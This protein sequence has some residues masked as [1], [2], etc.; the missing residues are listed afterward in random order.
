LPSTHLFGRQRQ[1][2]SDA[3]KPVSHALLVAVGVFARR[4][5]VFQVVREGTQRRC[6]AL[7]GPP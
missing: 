6:G 5:L 4:G 7:D 2:L 1:R 3:P